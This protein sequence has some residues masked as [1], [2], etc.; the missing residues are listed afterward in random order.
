LDKNSKS[1][2]EY[3]IGFFDSGVGGLTV[4]RELIQVLPHENVIYFGDTAHLPYGNKSPSAI[5]EYSLNS[6]HFLA[7]QGCKL[8]LIACHTACAYALESVQAALPIPVLGVKEVGVRDLKAATKTNRI[9]VLGTAATIASAVFQ[10]LLKSY[11]LFPIACPLFVPLVEE[12]FQ[13]H[14][15]SKK[16][17]EH[18]LLPLKNTGIDALL[19]GCTHYPLL[20]PIIQEIVGASV[21]LIEPSRSV[22]FA[23]KDLLEKKNLL[24]QTGMPTYRFCVS[25]NPEKFRHLAKIFFPYSVDKVQLV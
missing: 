12:G 6:A 25:D 15:V 4:M 14:E 5:V 13:D 22:A 20:A 19:L 24:R 2:S 21:Q 17:A 18:Y 23:T 9:A 10:N 8:I 11:Q 1:L 16:I 3:P 7:A